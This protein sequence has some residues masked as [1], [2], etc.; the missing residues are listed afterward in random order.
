[1]IPGETSPVRRHRPFCKRHDAGICVAADQRAAAGWLVG[2]SGDDEET[3][4]WLAHPKY[5]FDEE[6]A[7]DPAAAIALGEALIRQGRAA[8]A[9]TN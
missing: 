7:L 6:G 4:V 9:Q 8:L 3:V 5:L 1:V 2:L